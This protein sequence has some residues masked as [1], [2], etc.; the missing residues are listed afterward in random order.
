MNRVIVL[1]AGPLGLAT[2]PRRTAETVAI[3]AC[4]A[5]VMTAEYRVV[6]PAIADFEVRREL[7]RAGKHRS[8]ARLDAFNA[9]RSDRYLPLTDDALRFA[10]TLWASARRQG[11]PTADSKEL[12]CDVI[13]A[14][15][16]LTLDIPP[17]EL[18]VVTTNVGHL[19]LFVTASAWRDVVP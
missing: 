8:L 11:R 15:Q 16:A 17:S 6:V 5:R 10:A 1:D 18:V 19:S 14:A 9:A 3:R 12:D 2:Q 7:E 4:L 13:L